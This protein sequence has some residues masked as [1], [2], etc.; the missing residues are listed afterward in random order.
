MKIKSSITIVC[1]LI[2]LNSLS[3]CVTTKRAGSEK[4]QVL[5]D[6]RPEGCKAVFKRSQ[7][8]V[9]R[10]KE[11]AIIKIRNR[12]L[13]FGANTVNLKS[14]QKS[15]TGQYSVKAYFYLCKSTVI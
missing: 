1:V 12:A 11:K 4:I 13:M 10:T 14:I 6:T 9:A 5:Y 15:S 7:N 2:I 3:G 8:S